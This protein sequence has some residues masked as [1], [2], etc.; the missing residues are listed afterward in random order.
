MGNGCAAR[1]NFPSA[2]PEVML[3]VR[4]PLVVATLALTLIATAV[5]TAQGATKDAKGTIDPT[6][7]TPP[8]SSGHQYWV[9]GVDSSDWL[10]VTVSWE[11][12]TAD[13]DLSV[14]P[15]RDNCN[16]LNPPCA[17]LIAAET[18]DE[19][20]D[21]LTCRSSDEASNTAKLGPGSET[22]LVPEESHPGDGFLV[23]IH[24]SGGLPGQGIPYELTVGSS[25]DTFNLEFE[26]ETTAIRS[27]THCRSV[28]PVGSI[29]QFT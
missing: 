29:G 17:L 4:H 24:V 19:A 8:I 15:V 6:V 10:E 26:S 28:P 12:E 7:A 18:S 27:Q 20:R 11:D 21:D 16:L 23:D 3:A 9:G 5:P 2:S 1:F 22:F 13:L 25:D 14:T